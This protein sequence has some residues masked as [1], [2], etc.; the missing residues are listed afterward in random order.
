MSHER[1]GLSR[2]SETDRNSYSITVALKK[3][4]TFCV[5][6]RPFLKELLENTS[7]AKYSMQTTSYTL[8]K[9]PLKVHLKIKSIYVHF[10]EILIQFL[11]H[12]LL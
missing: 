3:I 1:N 5:F 7:K 2:D 10:L 11:S 8:H 4:T 6:K 9:L 12:W